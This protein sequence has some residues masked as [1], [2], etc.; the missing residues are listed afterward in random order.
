MEKEMANHSSVLAWR[1]PWTE[2]PGGL[3]SGVAESRSW[4]QV[5]CYMFLYWDSHSTFHTMSTGIVALG[6]ATTKTLVR[7]L[8]NK[9][10]FSCQLYLVR[11]F[12]DGLVVKNLPAN[13]GDSSYIP[14]SGRSPGEG[15]GNPL[16]YSCLENPMDS[17]AWQ[18]KSPWG[19]KESDMT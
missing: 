18:V 9:L 10:D 14:W 6:I 11:G 16:Q 3:Q 1:I 2:E 17:G 7:T 15:N 8:E 12:P 4:L 13:A 5:P 19:R